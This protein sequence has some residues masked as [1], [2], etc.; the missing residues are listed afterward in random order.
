MHVDPLAGKSALGAWQSA[1]LTRTKRA[2]LGL[3]VGEG[4][5]TQH[6]ADPGDVAPGQQPLADV[7]AG[8]LA[9]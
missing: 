1:S 5:V 2:R 8:G 9:V 7:E 6:D 4:S 3:V